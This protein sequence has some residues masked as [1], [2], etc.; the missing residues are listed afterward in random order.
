MKTNTL[1]TIVITGSQSGMGLAMRNY[2][3]SKPHTRIIG[4]DLPGKGAEVDADLSTSNGV[5]AAVREVLKLAKDGINGVIP[6]AGV[7]LNKPALTLGVNYFGVVEF[8]DGLQPVLAATAP[9]AVVVNVSNSVVIT[10]NIPMEPVEALLR[11]DRDQA[12]DLLK[13]QPN[14]SYQVSKFAIARWIRRNAAT[15]RWAGSGIRM[16]GVCPGPVMTPLLEHDL[17]D[18]VKGPKIEQLPSPLGEFTTTEQISYLVEFLLSERARFLVGQLIM[19]D[20]GIETTFRP[21]DF[22]TV[23]S[24]PGQGA[25]S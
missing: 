21:D 17:K 6:N 8:L 18:P 14:F 13:D 20:G 16:N 11:G 19:I 22:P 15:E 5:K 1:H 9:S 3:A 12:V 24:I 25:G 2:L 4:V 23:W 10:P 7:D